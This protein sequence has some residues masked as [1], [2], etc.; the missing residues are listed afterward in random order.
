[1]QHITLIFTL[2]TKRSMLFKG[3][4]HLPELVWQTEC[5]NFKNPLYPSPSNFFKIARTI[6]GVIVFQDFAVPSL[7]NDALH[8][9]Q[10]HQ[11]VLASGN[12]SM[13]MAP[14]ILFIAYCLIQCIWQWGNANCKQW[15]QQRF[16][17]FSHGHFGLQW[18]KQFIYFVFVSPFFGV[19]NP[20]TLP[21]LYMKSW[22]MGTWTLSS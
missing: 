9:G 15:H 17:F 5:T 11:P 19:V 4:F 22:P 13:F 8:T 18:L 3:A 7:Q 10:T 12:H 16:S 1:M 6:F 21:C 20:G 2:I 14:I